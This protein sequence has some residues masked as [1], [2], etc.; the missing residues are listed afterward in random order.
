MGFRIN[1]SWW[2]LLGA[3]S[4]VLAP[5]MLLKNSKFKKSTQQALEAN[6]VRIEGQAVISLP[7]LKS[8]DITVLSEWEKLEG[9]LA[10]PGV[11]CLLSTDQ[12]KLLFDVGFGPEKKTMSHNAAKLGVDMA[13]I[14][15]LA[16]S[17]MHP[18]H[19]GGLK[20]ARTKTV[21][22]PEELGTPDGKPCF[23]PEEG[24]AEGF[25]V[26]TVTSPGILSG[27][28]AT[29]GPLARGLFFMGYTEEQALVAHVKDKGLVVFTGCGHPTIEVI[30]EMVK[31]MAGDIPI[32]AIGGGLHFPVTKGRG[33]YAGIQ[34][35]MLI[36]TGKPP[37]ERIIDDDLTRTIEFINR[38][39][40]VKVLLSAH[41]SCDHALKRFDEELNADV[42]IL[43]AGATY[44]I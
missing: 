37:W 7:E 1:P 2:P 43:K 5:L 36:G 21:M 8:L 4:P 12:G 30:L 35:Q 32:Y 28:I 19:M 29:T 20:A 25:K 11:S 18:D 27:G 14:D 38:A 41:D 22:L 13:D 17:H 16:I 24:A 39:G 33:F 40:P 31:S 26:Q 44:N 34:M 9:F 6:K 23:L 15:A 42:T 10:D 3:V